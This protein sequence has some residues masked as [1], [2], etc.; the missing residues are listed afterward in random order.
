MKFCGVEDFYGNMFY[1][2]D[3]IFSDSSRNM[4]INNQ[5]LNDTGS[6]YTN[7]GQASTADLGGYINSV[8]GGTETGFIPKATTG[9]AT[10]YYPDY[11]YLNASRFAYFGGH[12]DNASVAGA[13]ALYVYSSASSASSFV[14]ARLMFCQF[15]FN[16]KIKIRKK[17]LTNK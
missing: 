5:S 3:G 15:K 14:G 1:W 13:F 10:T 6:G 7:Y 12:W 4:L 9:S 16:L 17:Y 11:G 8:Q 2:I